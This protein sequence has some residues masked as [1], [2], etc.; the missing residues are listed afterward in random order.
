VQSLVLIAGIALFVAFALAARFHFVSSGGWPAGA[1][2]VSAG[3]VAG[4]ALFLWLMLSREASGLGLAIAAVVFAV[5]ALL[6]FTALSAS[7]VTTFNS[8]YAPTAPQ[9]V[10]KTGPYA[11]VRHPFYTSYLLYWLGCLAAAP[12]PALLLLLAALGAAYTFA[13]RREESNFLASPLAAEYA[14]YQNTAGMFW[15]KLAKS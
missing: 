2:A 4:T 11:Y 3:T 12:H 5:S 14:A 7:R 13:A 1:I 10:V 6:F 9:R 8:V 15:P